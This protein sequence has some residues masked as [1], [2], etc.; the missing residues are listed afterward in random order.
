M[1]I[2][3]RLTIKHLLLNKKRTI[4]T[5]IGILLSMAL[6]LGCGLLASS[7]IDEMKRETI[8]NSGPY[9][10]EFLELSYN[11]AKKV[12]QNI[13]VEQSYFF[14]SLGFAKVESTNESK[15]YLYIAA[16][17][18][19]LLNTHSL[20]EGRMPSNDQEVVISDH[21]SYNGEVNYKVGDILQLE[22]G[23][24]IAFGEEIMENIEID[25]RYPE[26]L[27]KTTKK[28]YKIVGV[29][30]R[31]YTESYS[32]AGYTVFTKTEEL[33]QEN[34]YVFVEYKK[35]SKTYEATEEIVSK[36]DKEA[37]IITNSSLLYYYGTTKYDNI[38]QSIAS[39][40]SIALGL[41]SIGCIIVIY[42]SF[43]ISTMERKK[44]FGLY[45]SIGTTKKQI[46]HT[47]LFEAFVVGFIGI[48]L[49]ILS[50]FLGIYV[51]LEILNYLLKNIWEYQF[52]LVINWLYIV[53]P[54]IFMIVV[55][56]ISAYIPAKRASSVT[57]IVAIRE[58]DD[59]KMPKRKLKTPFWVVRFFGIE[60]ELALK[61]MK[62]NK[63][64]YR[65][66]VLSLFVSI[67]LF[68]SFS[69]YLLYGVGT[70]ETVDYYDVDIMVSLNRNM[71]DTTVL[72][73]MTNDASV[74]NSLIYS[75]DGT[76][77]KTNEKNI[78]TEEYEKYLN[79]NY[80][81]ISATYSDEENVGEN[82]MNFIILSDQDY[83]S[84]VKEIGYSKDDIVLLNQVNIITYED[85]N[86]YLYE[87]PIFKK[88][89]IEFNLCHSEAIDND[90]FS[91]QCNNPLGNVVYTTKVPKTLEALKHDSNVSIILSER[92]Y[93]KYVKEDNYRYYMMNINANDYEALYKKWTN[94]YK[95]LKG[96]SIYSPKLELK[97]QK[98]AIL[99]LKILLYGFISLVTLIGVTSVFNTIHTSIN[100]RRKEFAML[101]S[102]GLTPKGFNKM[103]LFE[104][105]FF[106]MKSLFYALPVSFA[107]I[108][109]I[110]NSMGSFVSRTTLLIPWFSVI[111]AI[112]GVFFIVLLAM[113]YSVHK[114][115]K[116]NILDCLRDENI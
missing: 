90:E 13:Q 16:A 22:V 51:V 57:P 89:N 112:F 52:H 75:I 83:E 9:H 20:I 91:Y 34:N 14:Q 85:N 25:N 101:R 61:N 109:L 3:N 21:M 100:L 105:L 48:V 78:Y 95:S 29:I 65:I 10:T 62:R 67:V 12:E 39:V 98:N 106:G 27:G 15:P 104:S 28:T 58:N 49:G 19:K 66:T 107:C 86:R 110:H 87:G 47:V 64:K 5:I 36:L 50:S 59:I 108:L 99:A 82:N 81:D 45:A 53:I 88:D 73:N 77:Y 113:S 70:M 30:K 115:K 92:L 37:S 68:I 94:D 33:G 7:F 32:G 96:L 31:S 63:K 60:G 93:Q 41:L 84:Y 111:V 42:N 54:I 2:L 8:V 74:T 4:V 35:P 11:D 102:M 18:E 1:G 97:E 17:N 72:K 44:Q 71:K 116:E 43:A 46:L 56:I 23:P 103:I 55:V 24:R 79:H 80:L 114:I 26:T 6:M 38:N 69:A 40:L 76:M